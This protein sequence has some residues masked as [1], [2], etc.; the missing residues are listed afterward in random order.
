MNYAILIHETPEE[1]AER[2]DPER[3]GPYWG[4]YTEYSRALEE[5]GILRG[6]AGLLPPHAATTLRGR[7]QARQVQDGPFAETKEQLGGFYLIEV[8]DLDEALA[9]AERCPAAARGA[10]EVRPTLPPPEL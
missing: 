6:G 7:G 8:A 10:V 4:A 5:A 2:T 9:W 3:S 1:F